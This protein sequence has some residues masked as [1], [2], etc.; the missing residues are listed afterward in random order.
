MAESTKG[1]AAIFP[2]DTR[3]QQMARRPGG[4]PRERAVEGA[5]RHLDELKPDFNNW[6]SRQLKDLTVLLQEVASNPNDAAMLERAHEGCCQLRDVG[7]TMGYELVSFVANN[8]CDI[9]D[10]V[11][12]GASYDQNMIDCHMDAL[13]MARTDAYRNLRPEQV[14]EMTSG[15]RRMVEL[16]VASS[17]RGGK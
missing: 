14:P 17:A 3:F 6:L 9:L 5:Q 15:L 1:D 13:A 7:G 10:A 4:V 11:K 16:A 12:A 2:V 8:F